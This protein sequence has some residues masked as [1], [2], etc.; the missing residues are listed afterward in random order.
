MPESERSASGGFADERVVCVPPLDERFLPFAA[1]ARFGLAAAAPLPRLEALFPLLPLREAVPLPGE[2][3]ARE[4]FPRLGELFA[5][6]AFPLLE[7]LFADEALPLPDEALL[8]EALPDVDLPD[9]DL[10]DDDLPDD[11]D[12]PDLDLGA[13]ASPSD[14]ASA[15]RRACAPLVTRSPEAF[16]LLRFR[17][18]VARLTES[19]SL[20]AD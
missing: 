8:D 18:A 17:A 2:A 10:P 13:G 6:E 20:A 11:V 4:A 5:E 16:P 14:L 12:L 7:E 15:R 9:V 1:A 3:F 19:A